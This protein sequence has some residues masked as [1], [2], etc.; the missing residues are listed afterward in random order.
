MVVGYGGD[1]D[2]VCS[3]SHVYDCG[4][5]VDVCDC[6]CE[7]NLSDVACDCVHYR[8]QTCGCVTRGVHG[9]AVRC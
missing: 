2:G 7:C 3:F 8:Q 9:V 6:G 4:D 5:D 1:D